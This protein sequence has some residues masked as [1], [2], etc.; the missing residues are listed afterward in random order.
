MRSLFRQGG[1]SVLMRNKGAKILSFVLSF[2]MA[3]GIA[4]N[5]AVPNT[6]KAAELSSF[7]KTNVLDDLKSSTEDGEVFDI[8]DYPLNEKGQLQVINFVE[9][10]YS[11]RA[12]KRD[13]YALYL[14]IYNPRAL[15]ISTSSKSN[16]VEM[17]TAYDKDGNPMSYAKFNLIFCSKSLE[18][19]YRNLFYK[20]KIEDKEVYGKTFIDRVNTNERR[21]DI[22]GIE[23]MTVGDKNATEYGVN[24]TFKFTGFSKGH[25]PDEN[26][27][28]N[29]KCNIEY[30][31]TIELDVKHTFYRT[32][33]SSK[34]SNYQNQVDSVYFSVPNKYLELYGK[35]QRIKAEWYEYKTKDIVV[36]SN[37]DLYNKALP[38]TGVITGQYDKWGN[39]LYNEDIG[40]SLGQNVAAT[41]DTQMASWG[42]NLGEEY[43]HNP[44]EILYYLFKVDDIQSLEPYDN[45]VNIGGVESNELYEYILNYD[46]TYVNGS[47]PIKE[48]TISADLF[49]EDIDDYRKLDNDFGKIQQGYS[50]YDFD[51]DVDVK[52]LTS[53]KDG[54][55]SFWDNWVNWG[56]F[57]TLFGEIPDETGKTVAPIYIL[58][59]EDL[60]GTNEEISNN[61]LVNANDV[62]ELKAYRAVANL[63]DETVV[64][65]RFATSDYYSAPLSIIEK[66]KGFLFSD[67]VTNGQAYRAWESVFFDFDIIQLTFNRDGIYKVIPVVSNPIDIVNPVTPPI[68]MGELEWWQI[69]LLVIVML[70]ILL[71]LF[72]ILRYVIKFIICIIALPF[73]AI[74][75]LIKSSKKKKQKDK[76]E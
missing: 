67:K 29:L 48:G 74:A 11:Y 40:I 52:E 36:T 20:F 43:L 8:K 13:N 71:L 68:D 7:D 5:V 33:T 57:N 25:G 12:N 50:Y 66:D 46:K 44:C 53:W 1:N 58:N 28:S 61:L 22:S 39:L 69:L 45:K 24:G 64:L 37:N 54:N 70:L 41:S 31:E 72:P 4:V 26:A 42:W 55:P 17:A 62:T 9:Y 63:K 3:V 49:E 73:K 60:S 75:G 38:Y 59:D 65:F 27:K 21:Y 10:C 30:L 56:F 15:N 76:E 32:K 14:Y 35:L 6:V 23:L 51:A 16:K 19:S 18:P 47:L 2:V 34:G